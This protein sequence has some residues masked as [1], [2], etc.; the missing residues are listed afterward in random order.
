MTYTAHLDRFARDNLP[1][2]PLWPDLIF[3]LPELEYP[4]RLH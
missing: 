1:P 4:D 2:R 3:E